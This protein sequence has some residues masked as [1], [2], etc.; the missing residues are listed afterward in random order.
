MECKRKEMT[1]DGKR[2]KVHEKRW[3]VMEGERKCKR[4]EMTS[5]G[6]RRNVKEK[7]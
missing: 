4:K 3:P 5:D 2:G 6:K 7:R 1:S